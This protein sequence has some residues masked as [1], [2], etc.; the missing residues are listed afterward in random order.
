MSQL[1]NQIFSQLI[2][3]GSVTSQSGAK[4]TYL[5]TTLKSW[6][7]T[8]KKRPFWSVSPYTSRNSDQHSIWIIALLIYMLF[9]LNL[10]LPLCFFFFFFFFFFLF[11]TH[12]T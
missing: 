6:D 5:W 1:G 4:L 11:L 7:S 12:N 9:N 10:L 2:I 8:T 3:G